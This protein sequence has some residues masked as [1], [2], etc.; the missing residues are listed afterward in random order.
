LVENNRNR[1]KAFPN[2]LPVFNLTL[3]N[4]SNLF[5]FTKKI[6]NT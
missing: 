6:N 3:F 5:S 2:A 4:T 1:L